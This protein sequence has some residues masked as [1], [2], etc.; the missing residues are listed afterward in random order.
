[1][2]DR[3]TANLPARDFEKTAA[4]YQRLGF[5]TEFRDDGWMIRSRGRLELEF[6]PYP[7]LQPTESAFSACV[8]VA[9]LDGLYAEWAAL[10]LPKTGIPRLQGPPWAITEDMRMFALIDLDGSLLR[11]IGEAA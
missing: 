4:F 2:T 8:R 7:D 11:C 10:G 6:F 1:M 9:D 5:S 3:I